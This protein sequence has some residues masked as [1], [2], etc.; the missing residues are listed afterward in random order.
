MTLTVTVAPVVVDMNWVETRGFDDSTLVSH[1]IAYFG[2]AGEALQSQAKSLEY[3]QVLTSVVVKDSIGRPVASTLTAPTGI[4]SFS[5][6]RRFFVDIAGNTFNH[7]DLISGKAGNQQGSVGWYYSSSN[8]MEKH[9]PATQYPYARNDYYYDG[10]NEVRFSAGPGETHRFRNGSG[11]ETL[12]GRFPV[13]HELDDYVA[14]R[15]SSVVPGGTMT[16]RGLQGTVLVGRDANHH[17]TISI[18]DGAGRTLMTA[19]QGSPTDYDLAVDNTLTSNISNSSSPYYNR[20]TYFYL[21]NTSLVTFN[22]DQSYASI[23]YNDLCATSAEYNYAQPGV[24]I[25]MKDGFYRVKIIVSG[26]EVSVVHTHYLKDITYFFYDDAGRLISSVSPNGFKQWRAGTPY[27][28]ID[29]KWQVYD[30]KGQVTSSHDPDAGSVNYLYRKDGAIRFSQNDKQAAEGHFSYTLYDRLGRPVESGEY[31]G[32]TYK[33][34]SGLS[35]QLEFAKQVSFPTDSTRDWLKTR[36]DYADDDTV[37]GFIAVTHLSADD[38][39]QRFVRGGVS[40]TENAHIRT[41]YSYDE[42]GR[43]TWMAQK[44]IALDRVF[45]VTYSYDYLGNVLHTGSFAYKATT[46]AILKEFYHHYEYDK[47]KRLSKAYTSE[48]ESGTRKLR[49]TYEYYIHGPLKRIVLGSKTQGI[50]FVYNIQGWLTQIN[51]PDPMQDPGNDGN[52]AFGMVLDYYESDMNNLFPSV[53]VVDPYRSHTTFGQQSVAANNHAPLIRFAPE[54]QP[55][56]QP[57]GSSMKDF[58]ANNPRY[59]KMLN[60]LMT[61]SN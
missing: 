14:K 46:G 33:F 44:P 7:N 29:K 30:F 47:D 16:V 51:H 8:T 38:Y 5:Y 32:S 35:D 18:V 23:Y 26:Y 55:S 37:A 19:N 56:M 60:S 11:N 59:K 39:A 13:V 58:S 52:D 17:Y 27:S 12:T 15:N 3:N 43:V 22:A 45:V 6:R 61:P 9:V 36:Y 20:S 48:Q 2:P 57:A 28:Q 1:G 21:L 40:T 24:P 53:A 10:T 50:D 25:Q 49:A 42:F 4:N 31:I 34:G 41:W 54:P